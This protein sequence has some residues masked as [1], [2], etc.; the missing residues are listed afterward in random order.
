MTHEQCLQFRS[1]LLAAKAH[2]EKDVPNLPKWEV[3]SHV[4]RLRVTAKRCNSSTTETLGTLR[5]TN[6]PSR[7]GRMILSLA[8]PGG[9]GR[10]NL[11]GLRQ[12]S[13]HARARTASEADRCFQCLD[14]SICWDRLSQL[15]ANA[16]NRRGNAKPC[17]EVREP[18]WCNAT[19]SRSLHAKTQSAVC[20]HARAKLCYLYAT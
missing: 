12:L 4:A 13:R 7:G 11:P 5:R 9:C 20:G 15:P 10:L 14:L 16:L 6:Q 8:V 19:V 18:R 17:I 2:A 3:A 1:I